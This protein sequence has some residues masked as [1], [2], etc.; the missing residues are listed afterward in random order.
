LTTWRQRLRE[1][2][3][4]NIPRAKQAVF[5]CFLSKSVGTRGAK[6]FQISR[7]AIKKT[8]GFNPK[9][10]ALR[11]LAKMNGRSGGT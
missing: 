8:E 9:S 1:T 5:W 7:S 10:V 2:A 6:C 4:V 3:A 11:I